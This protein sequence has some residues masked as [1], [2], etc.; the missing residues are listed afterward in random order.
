MI[1]VSNPFIV[2][3][4]AIIWSIDAWLWIALLKSIVQRLN[5]S[6]QL[7]TSLGRIVDPI[8]TLTDKIFFRCFKK[9]IP[10]WLLCLI[11]FFALIAARY[12][13]VSLIIS[14]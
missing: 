14:N 12:F 7:A 6:H 13:L 11:T 2:P 3:I 4:L 5:P 10:K 9:H 1:N 8:Q